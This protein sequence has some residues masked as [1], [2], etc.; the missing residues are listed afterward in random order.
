MQLTTAPGMQSEIF[1]PTTPPPVW[2]PV[3][4]PLKDCVVGFATAGGIHLKAQ[5][6]FNPA[7]DFSIREI[8]SNEP[9]SAMMV[10]HGG[11]DNSDVNKDINAMLP[12]DRLNELAKEGFI[13]KVA[14]TLVGFMG[15]GGN[16]EK[17]RNETGPAIAKILKDEGADICVLTAG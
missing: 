8:P 17:F 16:V 5:T 6:P 2:T 10:T 14:P 11:Y 13:G 1:A 15:G 7:G 3:S 12:V 9:V 4:K